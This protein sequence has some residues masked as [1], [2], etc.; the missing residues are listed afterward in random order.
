MGRRSHNEHTAIDTSMDEVEGDQQPIFTLNTQEDVN[1]T[2]IEWL[3]DGF[4]DVLY[5]IGF[6]GKKPL[7][8]IQVGSSE[9]NKSKMK[10][11]IE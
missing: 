2:G 4:S 10:K 8:R 6:A 1:G 11:A 9:T 3:R 7:R 5:H